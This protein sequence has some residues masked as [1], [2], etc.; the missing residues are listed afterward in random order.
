MILLAGLSQWMAHAI[1]AITKKIIGETLG[2]P[3]RTSLISLA[4][5]PDDKPGRSLRSLLNLL[6]KDLY[7]SRNLRKSV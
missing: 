5:A 1:T 4:N 2:V 7:Q 6:V 3:F